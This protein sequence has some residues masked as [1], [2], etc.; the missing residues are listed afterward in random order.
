MGVVADREYLYSGTRDSA[1]IFLR[2]SRKNAWIA[3]H[4]EPG[5]PAGEFRVTGDYSYRSRHCAADGL[6]LVGDA[7]AFLDPIFS[8]GVFLALK[9]GELAADAIHAALE[10]GDVSAA[11]FASYGQTLCQGIETM[12]RLVYAFYEPEFSF[13]KVLER[14]PDMRGPLTDCLIGDVF[15]DFEPL[16]RAVGDFAR[17]PAPLSHG[18]PRIRVA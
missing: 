2:E 18:T 8:S 13:R 4:L 14:Y 3:R 11:S 16:F 15:R 17:M 6:V 12:R 5:H 1:E 9:S 7:F 10:G